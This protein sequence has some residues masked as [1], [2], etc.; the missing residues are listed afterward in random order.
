M[1]SFVF[2]AGIGSLLASKSL[3]AVAIMDRDNPNRIADQYNVKLKGDAN[4][5]DRIA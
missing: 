2:C 1:K 3:L 4:R 5:T